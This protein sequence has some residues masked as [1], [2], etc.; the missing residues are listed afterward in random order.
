MKKAILLLFLLPTIAFGQ[1]TPSKTIIVDEKLKNNAIY[2]SVGYF[3]VFL[4]ASGF[5]ERILKQ[6]LFNKNLS[7]YGRTGFTFLGT[8]MGE[9]S[10]AS[11]N[12]GLLTGIKNHH[13]EIGLGP[14]LIIDEEEIFA[15]GC[16]GYRF[17]NPEKSFIFRCGLGSPEL[18]YAGIGVSF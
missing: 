14:G 5:Y 16:L 18:L 4:S 3:F 11:L 2:G 15:T 6:N 12:A 13:L 17:Q 7:L 1:M 9:A 8:L 10:I